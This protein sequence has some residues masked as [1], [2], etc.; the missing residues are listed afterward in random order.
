MIEFLFRIV[1]TTQGVGLSFGQNFERINWVLNPQQRKVLV[2]ENTTVDFLLLKYCCYN[3]VS[4]RMIKIGMS[5]LLVYMQY[6]LICFGS[7]RCTEKY[8]M[9]YV[10]ILQ[11]VILRDHCSAVQ[12][13]VILL[14]FLFL[15][16]ILCYLFIDVNMRNKAGINND[17]QTFCF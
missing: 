2:S 15:F 13:S 3:T 14:L 9:Q 8:C 1:G 12:Y 10:M 7:G 17:V 6:K 16:T 4:I 11:F 5:V